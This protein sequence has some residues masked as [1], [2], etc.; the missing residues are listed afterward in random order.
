M[1]NIHKLTIITIVLL[2]FSKSVYAN[3]GIPGPLIWF[4]SAQADSAIQ[5]LLA[6]M[7]MCV[8]IEGAIFHYLKLLR[9]PY[10]ASLVANLVSLVLGIPLGIIGIIDPTFFILPTILSILIEY[11]VL[12]CFNAP[13]EATKQRKLFF[14]VVGSNILTNIMLVVYIFWKLR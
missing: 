4:I 13:P 11:Y 7:L 12:K 3:S 1:K 6:T 2:A 9:R 10:L 14:P 5:W 8:G